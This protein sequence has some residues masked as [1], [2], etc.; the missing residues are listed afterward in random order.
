MELSSDMVFLSCPPLY[1]HQCNNCGEEELLREIYP[2][3]ECKRKDFWS[4]FEDHIDYPKNIAENPLPLNTLW[5]YVDSDILKG[6]INHVQPVSWYVLDRYNDGQPMSGIRLERERRNW[7]DW[8]GTKKELIEVLNSGE[9]QCFHIN[10]GYFND[11]VIILAE[12]NKLM[13][14]EYPNRYFFFWF[15]C[16]VSDCCIGQFETTDSKEEIIQNLE[17]TLEKLSKDGDVTG[18]TKM[19]NKV[20]QGWIQFR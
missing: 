10:L 12:T 18:F 7:E 8:T 17:F 2:K 11:D 16:D 9:R 1:P 19:K 20:L 4:Y 3:G 13:K 5:Q 6:F 14:D 15:D